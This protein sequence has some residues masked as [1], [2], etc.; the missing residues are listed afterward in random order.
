[1]GRRRLLLEYD[2]TAYRG[3]QRQP[4]LPTVQE[5]LETALEALCGQATPV[6]A[7][8]RTDAGVHAL[9]QV[10]HFDGAERIPVERMERA[11]NWRLP[12]EV[13]VR[14]VEE[15][16]PGFHA[17]FSA[18]ARI[19]H[20]WLCRERPSPVLGRYVAPAERLRDDSAER[21]RA[22]LPSLVGRHD[23]G[24]FCASDAVV[25]TTVRTVSRAV[26]EE[27]GALLRL[28][29]RADAFLK[30]MVRSIVGMLLEIGEGRQEPEALSEVLEGRERT[31]AAKPAPARG[32]FLVSVEYPDGYP[33]GRADRVPKGPAAL[34]AMGEGLLPGRQSAGPEQ[35]EIDF[36][37]DIH[38]ER[39]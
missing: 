37:E 23:F 29:L 24:A 14:A 2:G 3:F 1:V 7:A 30:G 28:E 27:S 33:A 13:T 16:P 20:Y 17:R 12:P 4:G 5:E 32:L 25:H 35:G 8:G 19:Y 15:A 26:L 38:G 9:G 10:V 18:R 39:R 21:M 11:L 34:A 6:V 31:R 22:A 36:D